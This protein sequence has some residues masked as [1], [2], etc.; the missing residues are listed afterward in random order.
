[1]LKNVG[2]FADYLCSFRRRQKVPG[3]REGREKVGE[4]EVKK[5]TQKESGR[6]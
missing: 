5:R 2:K 3:G 1:M 6:E 4:E